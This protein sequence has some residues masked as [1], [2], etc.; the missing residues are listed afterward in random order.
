[1]ID[2][3]EALGIVATL[4]ILLS[5]TR[6]KASEIRIVNSIGA[7]VFVVYGILIHALSVWLLNAVCILINIYKLIKYKE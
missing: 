6:T 3:I 2:W 1:M 5:F 7:A 4:I